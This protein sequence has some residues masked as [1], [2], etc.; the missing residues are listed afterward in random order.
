MPSL[1]TALLAI[2][3]IPLTLFGLGILLA[4]SDVGYEGIPAT[5]THVTG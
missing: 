1:S 3:S 4:P 2:Q 5:V